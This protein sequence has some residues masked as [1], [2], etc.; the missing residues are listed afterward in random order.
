MKQMRGS[1]RRL[2]SFVDHVLNSTSLADEVTRVR[3]ECTHIVDR[4]RRSAL[5]SVLSMREWR[6]A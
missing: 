1:I 3:L 4:I 2:T 6:R 5:S